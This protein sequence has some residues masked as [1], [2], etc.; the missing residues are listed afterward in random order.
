MNSPRH[1][2]YLIL[3]AAEKLKAPANVQRRY[4]ASVFRY[5]VFIYERRC[6]TYT[7]GR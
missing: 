7:A 1:F 4:A 5:L 2:V 6:V 3:T